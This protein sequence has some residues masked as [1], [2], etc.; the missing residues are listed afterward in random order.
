M[1]TGPEYLAR[2][3]AIEDEF[4][5]LR[6]KLTT[7]RH[8]LRAEANR[9]GVNHECCMYG[10]TVEGD[11]EE[12]FEGLCFKNVMLSCCPCEYFKLDNKLSSFIRERKIN[13]DTLYFMLN[14][15]R[16]S[17]PDDLT[18]N[19]QT[20]LIEVLTLIHDNINPKEELENETERC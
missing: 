8:E 5:S 7:A 20:R 4:A 1:M 16:V 11:R 17:Y 10:C 2:A 9:C 14:Q 12:P 3:R 18:V 19:E 13:S 6:N 15:F